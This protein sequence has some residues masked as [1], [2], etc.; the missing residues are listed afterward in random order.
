MVVRGIDCVG[1]L[2]ARRKKKNRRLLFFNKAVDP[3]LYIYFWG[4]SQTNHHHHHHILMLLLLIMSSSRQCFQVSSLHILCMRFSGFNFFFLT[5]HCILLQDIFFPVRYTVVICSCV[6]FSCALPVSPCL[7]LR[8]RSSL[9]VMAGMSNS[10]VATMV[11]LS[12]AVLGAACAFVS[13]T[14]SS[15]SCANTDST[16]S[17][18]QCEAPNTFSLESVAG[19]I[20]DIFTR[21]LTYCFV[22]QNIVENAARSSILAL[23]LLHAVRCT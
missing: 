17:G 4:G 15:N 6:C 9:Q 1:A 19:A 12:V 18:N 7:P 10:R 23:G 14:S 20:G 13:P 21:E 16:S 8:K 5:V 2:F 3:L 11:I 22:F